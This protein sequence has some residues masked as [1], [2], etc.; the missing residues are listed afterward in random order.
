[1]YG[2]YLVVLRAAPRLPT[3]WIVAAIAAVHAIFFISPPLALTDVFNYINYGR[4]EVRA[5]PQPLHHDPDLRAPQ[6][7][8]PSSL[9]NWHQ[10]LSPYGPMFTLLTFA[11]VPLGVAGSFWALKGILVLASL[12]TIYAGVAVRAAAR[13]RPAQRRSC[14]WG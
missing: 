3:R 6:R 12:A 4:M 9:S 11:V 13:T 7:P 5:Q 2:G 1:M 8:E 14:S 10:L